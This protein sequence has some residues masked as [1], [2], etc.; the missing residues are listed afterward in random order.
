MIGDGQPEPL[1]SAQ[2]P[3]RCLP[4]GLPSGPLLLRPGWLS[5]STLETEMSP[6]RIPALASR[7]WVRNQFG[8][9]DVQRLDQSNEAERGCGLGPRLFDWIAESR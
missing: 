7:N 3:L 4:T 9:V 5:H 6:S 2:V 8:I 1:L